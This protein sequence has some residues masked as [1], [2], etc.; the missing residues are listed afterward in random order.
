MAI[1]SRPDVRIT[2]SALAIALAGLLS[3]GLVCA[4]TPAAAAAAQER[5]P[6]ALSPEAIQSSIDALGNVDAA[7][8]NRSN[9][10]EEP[11]GT[12]AMAKVSDR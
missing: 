4:Q 3:A 8:S 12:L 6:Q 10:R 11:R 1:L 5:G 7:A 9:R 2:A